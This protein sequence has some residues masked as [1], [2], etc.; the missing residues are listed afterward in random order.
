[1]V[2]PCACRR[3]HATMTNRTSAPAATRTVSYAPEELVDILLTLHSYQRL[4]MRIS[5][6]LFDSRIDWML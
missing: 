2:F 6:C 3:V 4:A 5:V 1:M